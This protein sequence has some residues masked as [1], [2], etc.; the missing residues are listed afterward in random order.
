[1]FQN[2]AMP[3]YRVLIHGRNFRVNLEGRWQKQG[4]YTPRFADAPD[5]L[6]AAHVALEDFRHTKKYQDLVE[7]SLTGADDPSELFVE[8]IEEV[9]PDAGF[10]SVLPGLAL[11][12]EEQA[13]NDESD[14]APDVGPGPPLADSRATKRPPSA[15]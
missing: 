5:T 7:I 15:S 4:F 14:A 2:E 10:N 12:S 6:L 1:M 13:E 8:E 9:H 3:R 11:Y